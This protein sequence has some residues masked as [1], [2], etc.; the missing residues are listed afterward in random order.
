MNA[1]IILWVV[2]ELI[3]IYL[4][5]FILIL[6]RLFSYEEEHVH[7][8]EYWNPSQFKTGDL[9]I[10]HY[11]HIGGWFIK[12]ISGYSWH[13]PAIVYTDPQ[14]NMQY[15][16]EGADYH[17]EG[18]RNFNKM[19]LEMWYRLN[20]KNGI[21]RLAIEGELDPDL[22]LKEFEKLKDVKLAGFDFGWY[23]FLQ[24]NLYKDEIKSK[25]TC[26]EGCIQTL[27]RVGIFKKKNSCSS[28][29]TQQIVRRGIPCE[30]GFK[31]LA[32]K[33]QLPG[34]YSRSKVDEI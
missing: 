19:P 17:I 27:Q 28:Y 2:L 11:T 5:L 23:R 18:Y 20:R 31:Y 13:H 22:L 12:A 10:V 7:E 8:A 30:E 34:W 1:V 25:H 4:I 3:I 29:L 16:L 9:L 26:I 21:A 6:F 32:P 14:D 15:V 33:Y 24:I